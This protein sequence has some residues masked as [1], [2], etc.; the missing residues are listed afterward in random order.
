MTIGPT[1]T[2]QYT[3]L[4]IDSFRERGSLAPL[5]IQGRSSE[6]IRSTLG[7]K[8]TYDLK[9]GRMLLKPELRA[10]CSTNTATASMP[11]ARALPTARGIIRFI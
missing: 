7:F 8:A 9:V 1:A 10:A 2:F 6:S 3:C 5:E 4:D 11:S